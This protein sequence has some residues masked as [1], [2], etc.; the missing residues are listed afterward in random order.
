MIEDEFPVTEVK[1]VDIKSKKKGVKKARKLW[2]VKGETED[3]NMKATFL[4][5][6]NPNVSEDD[7]ITFEIL[8]KQTK[9]KDK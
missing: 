7:F 4:F 1:T 8:R 2:S 3:G 5:E 9:I 6:D